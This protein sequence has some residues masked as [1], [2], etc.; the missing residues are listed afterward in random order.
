MFGDVVKRHS[1]VDC[2]NL[3]RQSMISPTPRLQYYQQVWENL[4]RLSYVGRDL[5]PHWLLST[6]I[7]TSLMTT[8]HAYDSAWHAI[9]LLQRPASSPAPMG[10]TILG[11]ADRVEAGSSR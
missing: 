7:S 8:L 10:I 4:G 2:A 1:D 3:N 11:S 6:A 9:T 5:N